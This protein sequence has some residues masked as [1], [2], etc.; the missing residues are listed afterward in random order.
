MKWSFLFFNFEVVTQKGHNKSLPIEWVTQSGTFL[1]FSFEL[2]TRSET[3][4]WLD[5]SKWNFIFQ[6]RVN[7]LK[8]EK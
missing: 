8:V 1:F 3:I 2:V 4:I 7:K 5:N 6:L